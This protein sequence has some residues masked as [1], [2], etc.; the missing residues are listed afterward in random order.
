[1]AENKSLWDVYIEW[2]NKKKS[3]R[4]YIFLF[5]AILLTIFFVYNY[6]YWNSDALN[7]AN[8]MFCGKAYEIVYGHKNTTPDCYV[9]C[10]TRFGCNVTPMPNG[11]LIAGTCNC[12]GIVITDK[13]VLGYLNP[14]LYYMK[15][16]IDEIINNMSD[17]INVSD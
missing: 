14:T 8:P 16:N 9:E 2:C 12:S 13:E 4:V 17:K 10:H 11:N 3:P 1:M 7:K 5:I 6:P 15:K